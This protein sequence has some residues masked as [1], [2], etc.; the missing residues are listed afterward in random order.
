MAEGPLS[1]VKVLEYCSFVAGPFCAKMMADLGAEVIKIEKPDG[2]DARRRG[3]F[4]DGQPGL[5]RSGLFLYYN[6]NKKGV[7][8]D[9]E[10]TDGR[11]I[12][13]KLA[14]QTD[15]LIE[16]GAPGDMKRLG[17]HYEALRQI[18]PGLIMAAITPFG[19]DGPYRDY[20][21]HYLN[22]YHASGAGYVLP[23]NS[24][25]AEREPLKGG[26]YVGECDVG[27]CT[28]VSV[29][30]AL[31]W[32]NAGGTGQY[33]DVSKQE[34]MMALERMNIV[35][36]YELGTSPTRVKINRLR[37]TLLRCRDGGYIKIVLHPDNM[38]KGV[39]NA[40]DNP[41]WVGE[42]QFSTHKAREAN[43]D[44]LTARLQEDAD[45]YDTNELFDK[46]QEYGTACAPICSAEQVFNSPQT[47]ARE[48]Y[49]EIDHPVAGPMMYPGL[50]YKLSDGMPQNNSGAPML[51]E[52]N[53]E[54][55]CGRLG[56]TQQQVRDWAATGVI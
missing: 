29:L 45:K 7:T 54:I 20:K 5:E 9:L 8:L 52:H 10:T 1:G 24:P 34:A 3:P 50:P 43:F 18:N 21:A 44:E 37:D 14:S 30:G 4:K 35:R 51:G 16:D 22:T 46:I 6:T 28:L 27:S 25:N 26:G 11:D 17:L 47:A 2:D 38:W 42:E 32:R 13:K 33:I 41:E 39:A 56:Y 49:V 53:E 48:F 40:L 36:Y 19:Q 15:I 12:F 55:Y 23:A 31:F